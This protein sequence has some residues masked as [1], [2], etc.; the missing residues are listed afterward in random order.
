MQVHVDDEIRF[1]YTDAQ[2]VTDDW[3]GKVTKAEEGADWFRMATGEA[4]P[5]S[6]RYERIVGGIKFL[7]HA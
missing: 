1:K 7:A 3:E 2:G 5:R 4:F 6:F